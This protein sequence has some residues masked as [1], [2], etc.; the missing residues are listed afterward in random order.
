MQLTVIK[1]S[2]LNIFILPEEVNGSYWIT[3]FE[4]GKKINLINVEANNGVWQITSNHDAFIV[5]NQDVMVPYARLQNYAFYLLKNNYKNEKYYIFASPVYDETFKEF[6]IESGKVVKVGSAGNCDVC[7]GLSGIPDEAFTVEKVDRNYILKITNSNASVYVNKSRVTIERKI[8]YGDIIFMF[9]L[10]MIL[11]RKNGIDYFLV[12]NPAN[13][14]V[15]NASFVNITPVESSFVDDKAEIYDDSVFSDDSYF[16]RTPY[17]YKKVKPLEVEIDAPPPKKES[18]KSPLVLTVGPMLTMSM[19]SVMT[20]ISTISSITSHEKTIGE[21]KTSLITIGAMLASSILWPLVTKAT[22]NM[23]DKS[24]EGKR[25]KLYL[26]YINAKEK[27][28]ENELNSQRRLLIE[29][30]F[31]VTDCQNVIRGHNIKLWQRRITDDDFLTLP[32]GIGNIPMSV[33]IKYPDKHFTLSE[34]SLLDAAYNLGQKERI[35]KDVPIMYSFYDNIATGVVGDNIVTKAF[36]DRLILQMIAHYSYDELKIVTITTNDNAQDWEY[37]KVLP[38]G[39]SD[40]HKM[41]YFAS[42]KEE[43]NE[44]LYELEKVYNERIADE[45]PEHAN[46]KAKPHYVIITDAVKQIDNVELLK[47]IMSSEKNSGFSVVMLVDKV[48]AL[49]NECKNF[50]NVGSE[51]CSIFNSVLNAQNQNFKIDFSPVDELY[52][53]AKELANIPLDIKGEDETVLPT[54]YGFLEMYQVGKVEQL[55]SLERWKRNNP[56][57]SIQAPL[58]VG[59]NGEIVNLDLH[60]KYHGPHGLIAGTTGSGKSEFI[61]TYILSLAVNFNPDEVQ[62]VLIDYKGGGLAMSFENSELG[63]KL[64]HLAGTITNLDKSEIN[65]AI[66]SIE[67]ELKRRQSVFNAAREKLKEGSMNI[68]KYQQLY[69]KGMVDEPM[70]HLLIICDEFAELKQQ[71][72][73]FME[74]LI[75][76]SRIVRSLGVHLILATQKPAGVVND[77]IWSNSKFKVCLKVQDISDSQGVLKKPDAAYLKDTGRFYL[78]VGYDNIYTLGQAAWAGAKYYPSDALRKTVDTSVEHIDNI[79]RTVN[80]YEEEKDNQPVENQGEELLNVVQYI[81]SLCKKETFLK[82]QLWLPNVAEVSYLSDLVKKYGHTPKS[83]ILEIPI[84]EYDE[85][86]RQEQGLLKID[87][88][89]GNIG[90]IGQGGSGKEMLLSTIIW[91]S[92]IEHTPYEI[93]HYILDFGAETMRKFAKFPH[94]GEVVFQSEIDRVAGVLQLVMDELEKRKNLFQDFNGSFDFYNKTSGQKLPLIVVTINSFDILSENI[95]KLADVINGMF[96]DAPRYGIIFMVSVS[97]NS[98]LRSRQLQYFNH[99]IVLNTQDESS[100]RSITNCRK[101]L[102]PHHNIGR[103][104]CRIGDTADSYCEFQTAYIVPDEQQLDYLKAVADQLNDYYKVK[105]KQLAVVP[106]NV[107]SD[108]LVQYITTLENVPIGYNFYEKDIAKINILNEKLYLIASKDLKNNINFLYGLS[109]ILSKMPNVKV[110]VIDMLDYF[111]KPILDIKFFNDDFDKIFAALENDVLHRTES[112]DYG[113]NIIIGAG[114]FKKKLSK[115]GIEIFTNLFNNLPN[116]HKNIYILVDSY[117]K[118]RTLKLENWYSTVNTTKGLWLGTGFS[119]QSIFDSND[120]SIE[121]SKLDFEGIGYI[122]EDGK[123][124]VIKTMLDSDE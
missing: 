49:P 103:G 2:K 46:Q 66:S 35:L 50:I 16:Y 59:K 123:Y 3:D 105:A 39:W 115:G 32:L 67:S 41:R 77:Q 4:N 93:N 51:E 24:Y 89:K 91:S 82:R 61:V 44:I 72:P 1:K 109:N 113:V 8:E 20:L 106:D 19:T 95:P 68:Y 104:I 28:I 110:R 58:G 37:V 99:I 94:V 78:Q 31:S 70:S 76:T 111:A 30:N 43:S 114:Q 100:Y 121:D 15:Y 13:Q 96:R 69:R 21:A 34:D 25:K 80:Y 52:T 6:G 75:S 84:G 74:Q 54:S 48:V 87:L 10:K 107:T 42:S 23:T 18:D 5:D 101:G 73:E 38:H 55:N 122:I 85:P 26:N 98:G 102:I 47:K 9:G 62:F 88:Q 40:D 53:C 33:T 97:S 57:L 116:S 17:F 64:P 120:L 118:L 119:K 22:Q 29:N 90:I 79:G 81:D 60:E 12:N 14:V 108:D 7:Y 83:G 63:I 36:I 56:V 117:E 86:R 71:Q 45:N 65:R 27:E 124:K 11:L 92:M 112:Q